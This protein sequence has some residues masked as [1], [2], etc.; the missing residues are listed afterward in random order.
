M[1]SKWITSFIFA[2]MLCGT[3]VSAELDETASAPHVPRYRYALPP[4]R[5]VLEMANFSSFGLRFL[6]NGHYFRASPLDCPGWVAGDRVTLLAG[7]GHGYCATA[8]L[9]DLTRHRSCQVSCNPWGG[10]Y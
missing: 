7:E 5:H 1:K 4:E 6:T 9:R 10:P 8:V 3:A 2:A